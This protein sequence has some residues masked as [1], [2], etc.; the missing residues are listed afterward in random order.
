MILMTMS[1]KK[2]M[3]NK[4]SLKL[5]DN[6]YNHKSNVLKISR[7]NTLEHELAKF[8]LAWEIL[9]AGGDFVSEAIFLNGKRSDVF[10]LELCEAWEVVHSEKDSSIQ[11]KK[12]VYPC[13][14]IKFDS[15]EIVNFWINKLKK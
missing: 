8:F 3:K 6:A 10:N 9:Q 4:K 2:T 5:L 1:L 12:E 11:N 7:N 13:K 14:V 15:E